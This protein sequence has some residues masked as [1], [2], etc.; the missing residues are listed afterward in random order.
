MQY[1]I[2]LDQQKLN[3]MYARLFIISL[4]LVFFNCNPKIG[5]ELQNAK[6]G[7]ISSKS[8]DM[9]S[10]ELAKLPRAVEKRV[11]PKELSESG[12]I[13][14]NICIDPAG[15]V[16]EARIIDKKTS[17]S[18]QSSRQSALIAM[19]KTTFSPNVSAPEKECGTWTM[20]IKS[21]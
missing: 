5:K 20:T 1:L 7:T 3:R 8:E 17:L 21:L 14:F 9:Q 10:K 11:Y 4:L 12:K 18:K 15:K 13:V 16:I 19:K 6:D 2:K